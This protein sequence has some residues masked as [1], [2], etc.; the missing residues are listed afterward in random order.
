MGRREKRVDN[1]FM[2][3]NLK[4]SLVF[5]EDEWPLQDVSFSF[6]GLFTRR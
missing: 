5:R 4:S 3:V 2:A 1:L 6:G